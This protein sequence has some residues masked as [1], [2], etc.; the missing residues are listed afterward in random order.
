VFRFSH[1]FRVPLGVSIRTDFKSFCGRLDPKN[2]STPM[3]KAGHLL[4][5]S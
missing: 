4:I 5:V 1:F 3:F 2:E